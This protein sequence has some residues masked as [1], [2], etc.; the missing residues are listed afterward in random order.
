MSSCCKPGCSKVATK[1]CTGCHKRQYCSREC[2]KIAWAEHSYECNPTA[3]PLSFDGLRQVRPRVG[4]VAE[5][6]DL[7]E[8]VK[9]T[10][11]PSA[12]SKTPEGQ[13]K[14]GEPQGYIVIKNGSTDGSILSNF[15]V[16][17][18]NRHIILILTKKRQKQKKAFIGAIVGK[19]EANNPGSA[20][21]GSELAFNVSQAFS[22][23]WM[24]AFSG[25]DNSRY[26]LDLLY[27][28]TAAI[29]QYWF[30]MQRH[31]HEWDGHGMLECLGAAWKSSLEK[32]P[33][34]LGLDPI[35]SLPAIRQFLRQFKK[36]VEEETCSC[37][38]PLLFEFE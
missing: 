38:K 15:T 6:E 7:I 29:Y 2:Q 1:S 10:Y 21:I 37:S 12:V 27:G 23:V 11:Y 30:W 8:E 14:Q 13:C 20:M 9:R 22:E 5:F 35:F 4:S 17:E 33:E 36:D 26:Q 16:E 3:P 32:S 24:P 31:P 28:F 18:L 34:E 25:T 19:E